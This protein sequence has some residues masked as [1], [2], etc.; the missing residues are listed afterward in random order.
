MGIREV[1]RGGGVRCRVSLDKR[2]MVGY[3]R[4]FFFFF[5]V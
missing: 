5:L 3:N 4:I 2:C 1:K